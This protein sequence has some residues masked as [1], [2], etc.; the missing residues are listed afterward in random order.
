[1][2]TYTQILYHLVFS[3]KERKRTLPLEDRDSIFNYMWGILKNKQ[4]YVFQMNLMDDHVHILFSLYPG[5]SLS[6]LVKSLKMSS[7][8]MIRD[9][10]NSHRFDGWQSGYGAFT[11]SWENRQP[12]INYIKDQSKHHD[13]LDYLSELKTLLQQYGVDYNPKFII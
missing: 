7:G 1:M 2:S 12:I 11:V 13:R 4:C 3:T 6:E 9:E 5:I 8:K 10:C